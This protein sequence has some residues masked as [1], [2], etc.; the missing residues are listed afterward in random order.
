[1]TSYS[2][3]VCGATYQTEALKRTCEET[4]VTQEA[5]FS[6]GTVFVCKDG[7]LGILYRHGAVEQQTHKRTPAVLRADPSWTVDGKTG[8]PMILVPVNLPGD[9]VVQAK[10]IDR[11]LFALLK[12]SLDYHLQRMRQED[13]A[14][15]ILNELERLAL[16]PLE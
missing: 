7:I 13:K 15:A 16:K 4:P 11:Q 14:P 9:Y 6:L 3:S 2:C 5:P 1:M 12:T 10:P 8:S